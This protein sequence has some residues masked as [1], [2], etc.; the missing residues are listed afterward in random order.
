MSSEYTLCPKSTVYVPREQ[1]ILLEQVYVPMVQFISSMCSLCSWITVYA[2][3]VQ[4]MSELYSLFPQCA[5]YV[6]IL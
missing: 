3:I 2:P 4:F 5:V 1:F 6:L